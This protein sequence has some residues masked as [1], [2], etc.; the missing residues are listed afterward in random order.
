METKEGRTDLQKKRALEKREQRQR[1]NMQKDTEAP[2]ATKQHKRNKMLPET[3]PDMIKL[4]VVT[5]KSNF[6]RLTLHKIK[7]TH[8]ERSGIMCGREGDWVAL[9][10]SKCKKASCFK[11]YLQTG[12]AQK[13]CSDQQS[14][15]CAKA[16]HIVGMIK[17]GVTHKVCRKKVKEIEWLERTC[18]ILNEPH[19]FVT[20]LT[21]VQ[22]LEAPHAFAGGNVMPVLGDIPTHVIP[23]EI[24]QEC[25]ACAAD[26][27]KRIQREKEGQD[28]KTHPQLH[29]CGM[30]GI[31]R[32]CETCAP[33][34]KK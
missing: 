27:T 11:E 12:T 33:A 6:A 26:L 3:E 29:L 13:L 28:T 23:P 9:R 1:N 16:G 2:V 10:V 25:I 30:Q 31:N 19:S 8:V 15:G 18:C 20:Y 4:H 5:V 22:Q 14:C 7:K 34:Q 17:L 32:N 21:G 24:R